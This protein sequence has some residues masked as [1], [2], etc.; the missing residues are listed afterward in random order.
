MALRIVTPADKIDERMSLLQESCHKNILKLDVIGNGAKWIQNV[1]KIKFLYDYLTS[2]RVSDEDVI[3]VVDAF[4][5]IVEG[6]ESEILER[7]EKKDLDIMFSAEANFY[8]N[9]RFSAFYYR[10]YPRTPDTI[11]HFLNAGSVIGYVGAMRS[12][13][14]LLSESYGLDFSVPETITRY[15]GDQGLYSRLYADIKMGTVKA[16]FSIGLDHDQDLFG[17]SGGR[18]AV[19]GWPTL[20]WMHGYLLFKFE[21]RL[22]KSLSLIGNQR[23]NRDLDFKD[24]RYRNTYTA[25]NPLVIHLPGTYV[26]FQKILSRLRGESK[27]DFYSL[28][29]PIALMVS[30]V[31]YVRSFFTLLTVY[32]FN[33]GAVKVEE[34]FPI[35]INRA[36]DTV[37][38]NS[39]LLSRMVSGER[40]S[41]DL[42]EDTYSLKDIPFVLSFLKKK[43]LCFVIKRDQNLKTITALGLDTGLVVASDTK[44]DQL[45]EV[46]NNLDR[47]VVLIVTDS[48][49]NLSNQ[50]NSIICFGNYLDDLLYHRSGIRKLLGQHRMFS[51]PN[52]LRA[53]IKYQRNL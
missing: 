1:Y 12:M 45:V 51:I 20:S 30:F 15:R 31:A 27:L 48:K 43:K 24:G 40:F 25:T 7:F 11:Y 32:V 10:Y 3:M 53:K 21:R 52:Q 38:A 46:I 29:F 13:L 36:K 14:D 41:I 23:V 44:P 9:G 18:M 47:E 26:S 5:V 22:V 50:P 28:R 39:A 33:K 16:P 42:Q 34:I 35:V 37:T 19:V 6:S 2:D 4:D 49:L 8:L 17:C